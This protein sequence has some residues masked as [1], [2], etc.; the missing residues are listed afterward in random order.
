MSLSLSQSESVWCL[1]GK[2]YG[3]PGRA[4]LGSCSRGAVV[5]L[6]SAV[7]AVHWLY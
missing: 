5:W 4:G 7:A 1:G 6:Y 2:Y 3:S